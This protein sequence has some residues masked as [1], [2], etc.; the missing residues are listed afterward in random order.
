MPL[1]VNQ[2]QAVRERSS[3]SWSPRIRLCSSAV[4][5]IHRPLVTAFLYVRSAFH[6]TPPPQVLV[7]Q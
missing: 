2:S 4:S 3:H 6:Q 5:R 1:P 7:S